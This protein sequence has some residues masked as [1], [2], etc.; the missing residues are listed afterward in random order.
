MTG[1]YEDGTYLENN[2]SWHQEDSP[3]KAKQIEKILQRNALTPASI[4]EVGCG[5]GEILNRLS[6]GKLGDSQFTGYEISPQAYEI[7]SAKTKSNLKFEFV[8]LLEQNSAY[9]DLVLAIDVFEHIEDF[10]GFLR[11]LKIKG[12]YK[13]FHIPLD[14]SVQSVL[15]SSPIIKER[16]TVGHI[17]YFMKETALASLEDC[18]YEIVDYFYTPG[19]I[20]LPNRGVLAN[21]F[22]I[23]RSISFALHKDLAVRILG[24]YSLMVLAK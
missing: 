18:G 24:G 1:I 20:E 13:I 14:L 6:S 19:S 3:W 11:A 16:E 2:P 9:F 15:R 17:H 22:K 7:C 12:E 23:P 10:Y 21:L 4:C 8:N 5:A